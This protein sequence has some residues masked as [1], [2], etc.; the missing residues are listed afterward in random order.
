LNNDD[1]NPREMIGGN[2]P[3]LSERLPIQEAELVSAVQALA[4]RAGQL[5][6]KLEDATAQADIATIGA[7][8][9][10]AD[11]LA[12][13]IEKRREVVVRPYI[14]AENDVNN[15]F[16]RD[17]GARVSRISAVFTALVAAYNE[18]ARQ[19]AA[20]LAAENERRA[21]EEAREKAAEE[22][23]LR[24]QADAAAARGRANTAALATKNAEA[25]AQASRDAQE[26]ADKLRAAQAVE[27]PAKAKVELAGGGVTMN[28]NMVWTHEITSFDE[29]DLNKLRPYIKV[30]AVDAAIRMAI[31][32]NVR[33]VKGVRI[34]QK[35][36]TKF[37]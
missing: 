10:D 1:I 9:R 25:A 35:A 26:A 31:K 27:P 33:E 16:K 8:I 17:I 36:E 5:P 3:P 30:E 12:R 34:F 24:A 2:N 21:K 6:R 7:V 15:Y 37:K 13:R 23:R 19:R 4:D 28:Q 18:E 11:A 22:A 29:V 20:K 14:D 32:M